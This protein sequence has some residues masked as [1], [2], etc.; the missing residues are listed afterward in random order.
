[1]V[2][3]GGDGVVTKAA[4]SFLCLAF[5]STGSL[6]GLLTTNYSIVT[7]RCFFCWE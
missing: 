2:G 3:R 6:F 4:F 5:V 7:A 1:M